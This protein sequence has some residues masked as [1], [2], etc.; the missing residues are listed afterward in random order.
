M[1]T[2]LFLISFLMS[3]F[4]ANSQTINSTNVA[5]QGD[6]V[7]NVSDIAPSISIGTAGTGKTWNFTSLQNN[8]LDD[9]LF[10][11]TPLATPTGA[12]FTSSNL[13]VQTVVDV[14][15]LYFNISSTE[16]ITIGLSDGST[17]LMNS[18]PETILS[19]PSVFGTSFI[20][21]SFAVAIL[22]R[23]QAQPLVTTTIP[24]YIDSVR[25]ESSTVA[26]S[27]MDASG[28][29][30]TPFGVFSALRQNLTRTTADL[31][32]AKIAGSWNASPLLTQNDTS[33]THNFWSDNVNAKF[34]L[35]TYDLNNGGTTLSGEVIWTA[36]Y[37][38]TSGMEELT[39]KNIK[40]FPN[41]TQD[42][43][44]LDME[45][46]IDKVSIIDISGKTV[47]INASLNSNKLNVDFLQTG[48][49]F[50]RIQTS[51]FIGVSKFSKQ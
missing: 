50:L 2:K 18:N 38:Q 21:T 43:L 27:V 42:V 17:N 35:V 9:T 8:R 20:D 48:T 16:L 28:T 32:Y 22:S 7:I 47:Y 6:T 31:V 33:W 34:P 45:E 24:T 3:G 15:F 4:C 26:N 12:A 46:N 37:A 19:F 13:A 30:S 11:H 40:V 41:P 1:K 23:A 39:T 49:Y 51:N 29:L 14:N 36:R 5:I 10:F 44:T 25:I